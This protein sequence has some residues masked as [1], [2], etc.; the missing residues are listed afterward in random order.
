MSH[1]LTDIIKAVHRAKGTTLIETKN[2][3][4]VKLWL[5]VD[6]KDLPAR[7]DD[8]KSKGIKPKPKLTAKDIDE[9][10]NTTSLHEA[11]LVKAKELY[12]MCRVPMSIKGQKDILCDHK[13]N[14]DYILGEFDFQSHKLF[15]CKRCGLQI[16]IPKAN[17]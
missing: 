7:Y 16:R 8:W 6:I 4:V 3:E 12:D 17:Q 9:F 13:H 5:P 14:G 10:L 11:P 15:S 1:S 2:G